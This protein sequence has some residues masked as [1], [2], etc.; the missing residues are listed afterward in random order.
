MTSGGV[1]EPVQTAL[2][3]RVVEIDGEAATLDL[4][5]RV[6]PWLLV[7]VCVAAGG[8]WLLRS[9]A[10]GYQRGWSWARSGV[11]IGLIATVAWPLSAMTGRGDGLSVTEPIGD[12]AGFLF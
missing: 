2:R 4:F 5:V 11:V 9:P 6:N 10:G 12:I 1:L 7:G 8:W 3:S